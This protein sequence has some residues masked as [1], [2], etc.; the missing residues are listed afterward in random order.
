MSLFLHI[1]LD[2]LQGHLVSVVTAC[3]LAG[4]KVKRNYHFYSSLK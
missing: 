2:N 3:K 1:F 4:K